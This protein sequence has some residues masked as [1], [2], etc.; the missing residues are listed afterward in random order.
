MVGRVGGLVLLR[1]YRI[2][3]DLCSKP[4]SEQVSSGS[5]CPG[6]CVF[7]GWISDSKDG[8][9]TTLPQHI[10]VSCVLE[11]LKLVPVSR[12]GLYPWC[13]RDTC[14]PGQIDTR[15]DCSA[16]TWACGTFLGPHH[17][18]LVTGSQTGPCFGGRDSRSKG[19][20][21]PDCPL[22]ICEV[23]RPKRPLEGGGGGYKGD[24]GDPGHL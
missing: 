19:A 12:F 8:D 6:P 11:S 21:K 18:C 22:S 15:W 9:G 14:P 17:F 5:G 7:S 16:R 24:V 1:G 3:K 2:Y 13:C 23:R 20:L 4:M 10:N